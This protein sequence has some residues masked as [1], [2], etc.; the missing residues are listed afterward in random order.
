MELP[1]EE[2]FESKN[3]LCDVSHLRQNRYLSSVPCLGLEVVGGVQ[4]FLFCCWVGLDMATE[5]KRKKTWGQQ[6]YSWVYFP[7]AIGFIFQIVLF[8]PQ[9]YDWFA[10]GIKS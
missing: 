10:L 5:V 4:V 1:S 3:V 8:D 6:V 9:P 2:L 7:L